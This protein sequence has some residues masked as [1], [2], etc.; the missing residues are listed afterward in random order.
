MVSKSADGLGTQLRR[1][2]ELLDG[3]LEEIYKRDG[4]GYRP[5]YTPVMK[6]LATGAQRTIKDI[7]TLSSISH[8]AAS[9]TISR[10]TAE[11]LVEQTIGNDGRERLI[12]L[13]KNGRELLPLLKARWNATQKAA[14]QLDGELSAPLS[15]VL[16]EAIEA[17]TDRPFA[18]RIADQVKK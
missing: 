12:G 17:L 5:R 3:D 6:A 8:S 7:A 1:L 15:T 11:G 4:F 9:Q 10:M 14:N 2:V 16:A 18:D 13:T